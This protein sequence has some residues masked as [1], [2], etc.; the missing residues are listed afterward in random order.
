L[1]GVATYTNT[2][3]NSKP[4]CIKEVWEVVEAVVVLLGWLARVVIKENRAI[5]ALAWLHSRWAIY[6]SS[7]VHPWIR[8]LRD[9]GFIEIRVNH[10]VEEGVIIYLHIC[11]VGAT[12]SMEFW[13]SVSG[14]MKWLP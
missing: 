12:T 3:T 11:V 2:S 5:K 1:V 4:G 6:G 8:V 13:L 9:I 14:E 10:G 7:K